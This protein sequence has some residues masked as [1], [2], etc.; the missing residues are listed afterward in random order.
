MR[1]LIR[2]ICTIITTVCI[3]WATVMLTWL[4]VNQLDTNPTQIQ[5]CDTNERA[6]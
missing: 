5:E 4:T 6:V 2:L 1:K 3:I